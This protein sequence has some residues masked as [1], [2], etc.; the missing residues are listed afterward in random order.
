MSLSC[1]DCGKLYAEFPLDSTLPDEQW[2]MI[3]ES[4]GGLLCAN[5]MVLRA[6]KLPGVIAIRM[7]IEF[8]RESSI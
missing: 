3:H 5:C 7:Q 6:S 4:D 1:L 2:R 8:A